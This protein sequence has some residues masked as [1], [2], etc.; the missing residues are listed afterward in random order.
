MFRRLQLQPSQAVFPGRYGSWKRRTACWTVLGVTA[1]KEVRTLHAT[2]EGCHYPLVRWRN[3]TF[4]TTLTR[5]NQ[6]AMSRMNLPK[7]R[8]KQLKKLRKSRSMSRISRFFCRSDLVEGGADVE[9]IY[10]LWLN[11]GVHYPTGKVSTAVHVVHQY[12]CKRS[13]R[14]RW[15]WP[16]VEIDPEAGPRIVELEPRRPRG[17]KRAKPRKA[18]ARPRGGEGPKAAPPTPRPKAKAP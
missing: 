18:A 5:L 8:A 2:Y 4:D 12:D 11:E 10:A 6:G 13:R 14:G 7:R 17:S 15:P 3:R 1:D 9:R 16:T